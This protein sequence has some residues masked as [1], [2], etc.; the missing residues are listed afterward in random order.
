MIVATCE[1]WLLTGKELD[2]ILWGNGNVLYLDL[3]GSYI[4]DTYVKILQTVHLKLV[5]FTTY[6][7]VY[8]NSIS[9]KIHNPKQ[10][11]CSMYSC[12]N[13]YI[14][15]RWIHNEVYDAQEKK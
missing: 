15:T 12:T 7:V 14:H 2:R 13:T 11:K 8:I 9:V 6:N 5:H 10:K 3:G 4:G 1:G